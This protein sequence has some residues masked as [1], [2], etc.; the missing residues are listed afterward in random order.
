MVFEPLDEKG[1]FA[2]TALSLDYER[3]VIFY[4]VGF[5]IEPLF[6]HE[7]IL[8]QPRTGLILIEP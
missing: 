8:L 1:L 7:V 5:H 6:N 2:H 4:R 3:F